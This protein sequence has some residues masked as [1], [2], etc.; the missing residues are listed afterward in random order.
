MSCDCNKAKPIPACVTN[1]TI[2][3]GEPDTDYLVLLKTSDNRID[4]YPVTSDAD[5][6]IIVISPKV[7]TNTTYEV[8]VSVDDYPYSPAN[9]NIRETITVGDTDV[10]C[11]YLEFS[12]V[13]SDQ[14]IETFAYQTVSLV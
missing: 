10:E 6:T 7:R 13:Y 2:G 8:W 11:L 9:I 12:P 1:L 14:D 4:T 3:V 5:G